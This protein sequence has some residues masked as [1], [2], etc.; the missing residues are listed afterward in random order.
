MRGGAVTWDL[1][2]LRKTLAA[3]NAREA[4]MRAAG[5]GRLRRTADELAARLPAANDHDA[6]VELF[7]L[8]RDAA[9]RTI[10]LRPFDVQI[11]AGLALHRGAVA[12]MQ[13]GE[14]KT[15]AAVAPAAA[16]ALAGT[17][18]HILTFNDYLARRD[19]AWMGPVYRALGLTVGCI[20]QGMGE[21]ER[22]AAYANRVVYATA[23]EVGF[24]YLRDQ[25]RVDPAEL[26]LPEF[27]F[28]IVD[29]ADSLMIDEARIPLVIAGETKAPT[30]NPRRL[31]RAIA[32]LEPG[33]D[34]ETDQPGRNVHLT[35]QGLE[36]VEAA[37]GRRDLYAPDSQGLLAAVNLAL[38]AETLLRRDVDYIVRGG[39]IELVDEFTGRVAERRRWPDGLQAALE[40]KEGVGV[41][42]Q[43]ETLGSITLQHFLRLYP[44]LS[45]MTATATEAAEELREFYGLDVVVIPP[46]RPCVR[47]DRHDLIFATR[48]AKEA[49]V[50]AEVARAHASGRPVL[51]GTAS[52]L[53][54]ER[55]AARLG[56]LGVACQALNAK[57]DE[58]EARIVARAGAW[59]AV[60][61]STN[62]AGRGVDI[63][64][65]AD[66]VERER[67]VALGGLDVIGT[68]RHESRRV[69]N[70]L[71]GRA[72]RQGDPGESRFFVSL[73]DDLV[74]KFALQEALPRIPDAASR[75]RPTDDP[76]ASR[77]IERAQRIIEGQNFAIRK[78]LWRYA[79][80]LEQQRRA[81]R[82]WRDDILR[83]HAPG[84]WL[85]AA[86]PA[87]WARIVDAVGEA[88]ARRAERL[89]ALRCLDRAWSDHL[90]GVQEL[91]EGAYLFGFNTNV[92]GM[93]VSP[94][95]E[96][97]RRADDAFRALAARVEA[98][99]VGAL[100]TARITADGVEL[101]DRRLA[102]PTATWTYLIDDNPFGDA[103]ARFFRGLKRMVFGA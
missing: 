103:P 86:D 13:T 75:P 33:R 37:L 4:A 72:G 19:A 66:D 79:A 34:Y 46:H 32:R 59:G 97:Q 92:F 10:G 35:E 1:K 68:N 51:V 8:A 89:V 20:Q 63:R 16:A 7:A 9:R 49:A 29:E 95:G 61:I 54:S 23:K 53:E 25:L 24:D 93:N 26:L 99:I 30:I 91:R 11:L 58:R 12:E 36:R 57:N 82:Q 88:A 73:E 22:R 52:V 39:K 81:V 47:V 50:A 41:Q 80:I 87:A 74:R 56:E 17:P 83:D 43:G 40:A 85:A 14:G 48:E 90:A 45:G 60:T 28:A 2:P 3:I 101:A 27:G 71:R 31:A 78:D 100:R 96:F 15:L 6:L 84:A 98:A 70:Q 94:L 5:D 67:I 38:Q 42:N 77:E 18:V 55:L 69:D 64:L 102:G 62:M 76:R 21:A 44:R 65:G